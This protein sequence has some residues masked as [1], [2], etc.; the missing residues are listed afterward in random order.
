MKLRLKTS[1]YIDK[2]SEWQVKLKKT[3]RFIETELKEHIGNISKVYVCGP[4]T[5]N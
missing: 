3:E 1:I 4:P 5:M 2:H